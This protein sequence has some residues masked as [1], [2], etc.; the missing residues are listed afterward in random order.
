MSYD[1]QGKARVERYNEK[2]EPQKRYWQQIVRKHMEELLF[3]DPAEVGEVREILMDCLKPGY[4]S[5]KSLYELI[6]LGHRLHS[7]LLC[8]IH[9]RA[10]FIPAVNISISPSQE[11][12]SILNDITQSIQ[13]E[14]EISGIK[15]EDLPL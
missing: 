8:C 10:A 9:R 6:C 13:E 5:D 12:E 2:L 15:F 3:F 11:Y 14:V 4:L 7:T 1:S